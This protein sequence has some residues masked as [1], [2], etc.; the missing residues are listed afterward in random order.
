MGRVLLCKNG[1]I[2]VIQSML[3]YTNTN[4]SDVGI[5][6]EWW[7]MIMIMMNDDYGDNDDNDD[8]HNY[9]LLVESQIA[10]KISVASSTTQIS[11]INSV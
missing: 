9:E 6:D 1:V 11:S 8:R 3:A 7:V 2:G 4:D 5:L 10:P